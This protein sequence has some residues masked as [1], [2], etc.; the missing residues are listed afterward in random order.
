VDAK[1][2]KAKTF[3]CAALDNASL[4]PG[5]APPSY[6]LHMAKRAGIEP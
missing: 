5:S 4:G 1:T 3:R 2:H 6:A